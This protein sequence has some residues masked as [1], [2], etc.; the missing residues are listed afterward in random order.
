MHL[1]VDITEKNQERFMKLT[2]YI[3]NTGQV[4]LRIKIKSTSCLTAT[5]L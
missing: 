2:H 4:W 5:L 1:Q 3:L